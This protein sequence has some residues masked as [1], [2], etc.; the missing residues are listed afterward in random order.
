MIQTGICLS[1]ALRQHSRFS[2]VSAIIP[3][4]F[5]LK[6]QV[7]KLQST[8]FY[9]QLLKWFKIYKEIT[10]DHKNANVINYMFHFGYN[11]MSRPDTFSRNNKT[12]TGI[13]KQRFCNTFL[14]VMPLN[15]HK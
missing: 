8:T 12:V 6:K 11:S 7:S 13:W 9:I 4:F 2:A 14:L 1:V 5:D 3:E 15:R 10:N